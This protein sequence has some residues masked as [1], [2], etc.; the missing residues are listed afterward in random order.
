MIETEISKEIF[1]A[2]EL[3][4]EIEE[5][6]QVI[7]HCQLWATEMENAARIWPTTYIIDHITRQKYPLVHVD[8]I[9]MY[10]EWTYIPEG[11]TL[12]FTLIFKGLPKSCKSFDL[13]ELISEPG[14][15]EFPNIARNSADVYHIVF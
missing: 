15:F 2:P 1:I 14:A 8:G 7:I 3:L 11:S 6:S 9:S 10:P 12:N 4:T 13:V 5:E